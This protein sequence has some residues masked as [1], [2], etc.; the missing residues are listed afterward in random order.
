VGSTPCLLY[1]ILCVVFEARV[2][3]LHDRD[4]AT[5]SYSGG[6]NN[7]GGGVNDNIDDNNNNNENDIDKDSE[8][9]WLREYD[10][11]K[12]DIWVFF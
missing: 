5:I 3:N 10:H 6:G 1:T 12:I 2:I 8:S 11:C 7:S 4:I 9:F